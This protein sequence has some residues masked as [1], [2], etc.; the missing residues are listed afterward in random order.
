V[1]RV[2]GVIVA[3]AL[4]GLVTAWV[5][6]PGGSGLG[7]AYE[8]RSSLGNLSAPWVLLAFFAGARARRPVGG[9]VLGSAA[10][11]VAL[12]AFYVFG[13]AAVDIGLA[14]ELAANRLY[15]EGGVLSGP[16]AGALG[17][18]WARARSVR[19]SLVAGIL[20][21]GEPFAAA[22]Y[23]LLRDAVSRGVYGLELALGL[24]ACGI[25]L[26]RRALTRT[27]G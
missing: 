15:F 11:A 26:I 18:W 10:T 5:K 9:A 6:D 23:G 1:R 17:A 20:L 21:A 3:A 25:P 27:P 24:A 22:A 16:L 14:R 8:L 2:A 12:F 13:A 7:S 19:A 4:F